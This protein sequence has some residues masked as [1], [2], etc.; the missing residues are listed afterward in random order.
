[1]TRV[2][3]T[4]LNRSMVSVVLVLCTSTWMGDVVAVKNVFVLTAC[5]CAKLLVEQVGA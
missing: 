4:R 5:A 3:V 1:M 2:H